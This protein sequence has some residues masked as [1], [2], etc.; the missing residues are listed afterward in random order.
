VYLQRF[1]SKGFNIDLNNERLRSKNKAIP[2]TG[3][4]VS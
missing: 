2:V 1:V 3:C 4:G